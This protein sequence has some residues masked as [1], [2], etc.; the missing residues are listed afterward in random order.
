MKPSPSTDSG[1]HRSP[2]ADS[3]AIVRRHLQFGWWS[4]LVFLVVGTVLEALHGFKFAWYLNV[5]NDTRRMLLTLGHAHGTLLA[6][7]NLAFAATV[8]AVPAW[9]S[10]GRIVAS[11]SLVA[12]S[13]MIPAG[14]ILGGVIIHGSDPGLGILL[15]PPGALLLFLAVLLTA[16][17]TR[18]KG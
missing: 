17:A 10:R 7:V 9:R 11:R 4:L 16:R 3:T 12:A 15:V 2:D 8:T 6:L 13:V 1:D 14:F 18:Q 5:S